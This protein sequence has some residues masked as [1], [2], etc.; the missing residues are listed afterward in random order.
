MVSGAAALLLQ[1]QPTMTAAQVKFEL[2]S[3]SAYMIDA[4]V[5]GAGAAT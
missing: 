4:G 2:Q 3:G 5:Y 1:A